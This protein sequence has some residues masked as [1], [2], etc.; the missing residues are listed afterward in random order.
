[1][2]SLGISPSLWSYDSTEAL[3]LMKGVP[4]LRA[5]RHVALQALQLPVHS[6]RGTSC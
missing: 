6:Y 1:M 4:A 5:E 2:I 3:G